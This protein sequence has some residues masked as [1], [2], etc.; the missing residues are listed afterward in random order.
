MSFA[1]KVLTFMNPNIAAVYDA[2][3]S[4]RLKRQSSADLNSLFVSTKWTNSLKG[5]MNQ[6]VIYEQRV[7]MVL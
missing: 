2:V 7:P 3:I 4:D 5:R 6:G 1:S